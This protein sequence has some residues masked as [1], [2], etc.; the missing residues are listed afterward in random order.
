M[1]GAAL[2]PAHG[3]TERAGVRDRLRSPGQQEQ[4]QA[5]AYRHNLGRP[6]LLCC[7]GPIELRLF[8]EGDWAVIDLNYCWM[9]FLKIAHLVKMI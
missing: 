3:G 2:L 9:I 4:R 6:H 1:G 5:R 7:S 8:G